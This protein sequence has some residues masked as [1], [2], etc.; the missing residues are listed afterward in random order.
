MNS[1]AIACW[2]CIFVVQTFEE[3]GFHMLGVV[4]L[5]SFF[6]GFNAIFWGSIFDHHWFFGTLLEQSLA[7][8][9]PVYVSI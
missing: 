6:I 7:V 4:F 5:F 1:F 3:H 2:I 9:D 8:I